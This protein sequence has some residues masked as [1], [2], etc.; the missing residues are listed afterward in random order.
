MNTA[1]VSYKDRK[2]K[3]LETKPFV[4]IFR[5]NEYFDDPFPV[6]CIECGFTLGEST[7]EI[8]HMVLGRMEAQDIK[9]AFDIRCKNCKRSYRIV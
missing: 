3:N 1:Q 5:S 4:T 7:N 2:R 6:C 9:R 8:S